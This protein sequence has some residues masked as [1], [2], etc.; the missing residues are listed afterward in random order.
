LGVSFNFGI[1][2][3]LGMSLCVWQRYCLVYTC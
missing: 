2:L 1:L 3:I